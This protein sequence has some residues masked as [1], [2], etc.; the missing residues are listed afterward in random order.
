MEERNSIFAKVG[1]LSLLV[2]LFLLHITYLT[3]TNNPLI[4]IFLALSIGLF[5]VLLVRYVFSFMRKFVTE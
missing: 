1:L 3:G 4:Y 2:F 5:A